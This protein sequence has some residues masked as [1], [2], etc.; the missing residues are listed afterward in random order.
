MCTCHAFCWL[1]VGVSQC[2]S[3]HDGWS[4]GPGFCPG[5]HGFSSCRSSLVGLL[6]SVLQ[7]VL[8]P[9]PE[10]CFPAAG[11]SSLGSLLERGCAESLTG[12]RADFSSVSVFCLCWH[13]SSALREMGSGAHVPSRLGRRGPWQSAPEQPSVL[14]PRPCPRAS[15]AAYP[16]PPSSSVAVLALR[17]GFQSFSPAARKA[18]VGAPSCGSLVTQFPLVAVWLPRL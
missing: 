8:A 1:A 13:P 4:T 16:S 12:Q 7:S 6:G 11:S 3:A 5:R 18:C 2:A 17:G 14:R 10:A 9:P 15:S